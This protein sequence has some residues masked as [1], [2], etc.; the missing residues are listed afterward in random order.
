M[1][2]EI[3]IQLLSPDDAVTNLKNG[4]NIIYTF[5]GNFSYSSH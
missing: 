1:S 5:E 3:N 4:G 2:F